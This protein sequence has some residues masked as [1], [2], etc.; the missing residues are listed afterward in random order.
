[1]TSNKI[2]LQYTFL[3]FLILILQNKD[4]SPSCLGFWKRK[5]TSTNR[6]ASHASL[7]L[8][9]NIICANISYLCTTKSE[10]R[11]HSLLS[12]SDVPRRF[13]PLT[14]KLSFR[15]LRRQLQQCS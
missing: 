11:S 7:F 5:S 9:H 12:S 6:H 14:L 10:A 1:M 3:F 8:S 15:T 4:L 13:K 2:R